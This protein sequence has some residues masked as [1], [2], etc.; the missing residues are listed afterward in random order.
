MAL[1]A[2]S[3]ERRWVAE[4]L[5]EVWQRSDP[6]PTSDE[7]WSL[8]VE[9]EAVPE[10]AEDVDRPA[11]PQGAERLRARPHGLEQERQL[12][13]WRL[14]KAHRARE[15]SSGRLEHEELPGHTGVELSATEPQQRVRPDLLRSDDLEPLTASLMTAH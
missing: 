14:A 12:T 7:Q 2:E 8:D 5:C 13:D 11:G 10:R 9:V 6:H 15:K 4:R 1:G 3:Q